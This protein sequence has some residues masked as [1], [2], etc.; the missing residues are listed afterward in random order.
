VKADRLLLLRMDK[1]EYH[2][3]RT[4]APRLHTRKR[5]DQQYKA[6]SNLFLGV[7]SLQ[8]SLMEDKIVLYKSQKGSLPVQKYLQ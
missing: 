8:F 2:C 6:A 5:H 4:I 7:A 1:A 3:S